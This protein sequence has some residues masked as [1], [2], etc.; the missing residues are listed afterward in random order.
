MIDFARFAKLKAA[1][2]QFK[3][4]WKSLWHESSRDRGHKICNIFPILIQ[5]C[6]SR[7]VTENEHALPWSH[8]SG[9]KGFY[10]LRSQ[11]IRSKLKGQR[12]EVRAAVTAA[13]SQ[14]SSGQVSS[15]CCTGIRFVIVTLGWESCLLESRADLRLDR[16][17]RFIEVDWGR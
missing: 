8:S 10:A 1:D 6:Y 16:E 11:P 5:I 7:G 17:S 4:Q 2:F 3:P 14:T 13:H 9:E 12:S 15:K